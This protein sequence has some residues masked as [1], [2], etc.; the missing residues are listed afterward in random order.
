MH[1][2]HAVVNFATV[3]V[4]LPTDAHRISAAFGRARLVHATDRVGVGVLCGNDLLT[5][6]SELLFI[7]L[8]RFE[9]T[10]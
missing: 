5:S 9:K 8:D 10:L 4:P 3:S 1:S 7:P 6:I 2:H